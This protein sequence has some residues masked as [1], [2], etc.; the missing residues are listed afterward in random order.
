M[1]WIVCIVSSKSNDLFYKIEDIM[2]VEFLEDFFISRVWNVSWDGRKRKVCK[3]LW[4]RGNT[5]FE[6]VGIISPL[7]FRHMSGEHSIWV[8]RWTLNHS[9]FLTWLVVFS[10]LFR[11]LIETRIYRCVQSIFVCN[12]DNISQLEWALLHPFSIA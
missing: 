7:M 2:R 6:Y 1:C 4:D 5:L 9:R 10:T 12:E 11:L 8:H 3:T